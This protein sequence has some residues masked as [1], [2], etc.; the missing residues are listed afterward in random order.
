MYCL[1]RDGCL[2]EACGVLAVCDPQGGAACVLRQ[3]LPALQHRGEESAGIAVADSSGA[4]TRRRG[5]GLIP[6]ALPTSLIQSLPGEM[7]IGHTRYST[8]GHCPRVEDAQPLLST[9]HF[10]TTAIAHNGNLTNATDLR[11]GLIEA[12]FTFES[13]VDSEVIAHLINLS[14]ASSFTDAL[15]EALGQVE[16]SYCLVV[17]NSDAGLFCV[18]DQYGVCPLVIG[19]TK[20]MEQIVV[21]SESCAFSELPRPVHDWREVEPGELIHIYPGG[22][23]SI[24]LF[25]SSPRRSCIFQLIYFARPDSFVFGV[26]VGDFRRRCGIELAKQLPAECCLGEVAPIP[27]SGLAFGYG[28][29]EGLN[30]P[31]RLVYSRNQYYGGRAFMSPEVG[32]RSDI[33]GKK[34]FV[35]PCAVRGRRL[36]LADDSIVR[37]STISKDIASVRRHNPEAVW[38]AIGSPPV[39]APCFWGV[40]FS[41]SEE[42]IAT[43]CHGDL[44]ESTIEAIR[45]RIGADRLYYLPLEALKKAAGDPL[46]ER[47][48]YQCFTGDPAGLPVPTDMVVYQKSVAKHL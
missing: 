17:L 4:I 5:L 2:K 20:R 1:G 31:V 8:S 7:A 35:D 16:G 11:N 40:D 36:I 26:P 33:A 14:E 29:A 9:G 15:V 37:G 6:Q 19:W 24:Y 47:F 27:N 34:I 22:F 44:A 39:V 12:G 3:A 43:Q 46:G 38:V 45:Q 28:L 25:N 41:T 42:L 13:A 18:R 23:E 10:G 30:C 32:R 21:A 48:C